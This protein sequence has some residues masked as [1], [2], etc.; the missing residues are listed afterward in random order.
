M[1]VKQIQ[2]RGHVGDDVRSG[3]ESVVATVS[4]YHGTERFK[5]IK[6]IARTGASYTGAMTKSTTH[7]V[8]IWR[9]ELEHIQLV[10]VGLRIA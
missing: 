4:G 9:E 1:L 8:I 3:M 6:L 10:T 5:L 7:L 2:S